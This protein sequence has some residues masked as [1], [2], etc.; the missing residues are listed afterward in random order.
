MARVGAT[1]EDWRRRGQEQYLRG[2]RLTWK[3]Y[4]PRR[5]SWDHEHCEF[6]WQKFMVADDADRAGYTNLAGAGTR[7]GE[8]WI[9]KACFD[10]FTDELEWV[11]VESD[12]EAWP[13][14]D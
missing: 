6:C 3:R 1:A 9:C 7:A 5:P 14:S 11:V 8:W 2:V 12:P 4:Q 13:Y 10:D